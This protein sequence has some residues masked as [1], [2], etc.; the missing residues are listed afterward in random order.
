MDKEYSQKVDIKALQNQLFVG[1]NGTSV[2]RPRPHKHKGHPQGQHLLQPPCHPV[3]TLQNSQ[4]RL[5]HAASPV[6]KGDTYLL[7]SLCK[8][9]P[10]KAS[11]SRPPS[12]AFVRRLGSSSSEDDVTSGIGGIHDVGGDF[13]SGNSNNEH[14][15]HIRRQYHTFQPSSEEQET[16]EALHRTLRSGPKDKTTKD[17]RRNCSKD[18]KGQQRSRSLIHRLENYERKDT[19]SYRLSRKDI[20]GQKEN[21]PGTTELHSLSKKVTDETNEYITREEQH[22]I[23]IED[24]I[25]EHGAADKGLQYTNKHQQRMDLFKAK[26]YNDSVMDSSIKKR[27]H[28]NQNEP[29]FRDTHSEV[30]QK[31]NDISDSVSKMVQ[32]IN[33]KH[34]AVRKRYK[35]LQE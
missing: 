27:Y 35:L 32:K 13:M 10:K 24:R 6:N 26:Q 9:R 11:G 25:N 34:L 31:K 12:K 5:L 28:M 4:S 8:R 19:G 22:Q 1:S 2:T 21:V 23:P 30:P 33:L 18:G 16:E 15:F 17:E 20:G 29:S 7:T 3:T 14:D